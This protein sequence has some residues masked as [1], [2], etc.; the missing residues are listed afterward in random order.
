MD[1][2]VK[3]EQCTKPSRRASCSAVVETKTNAATLATPKRKRRLTEESS[4]PTRK[5]QR[6][7]NTLKTTLHVDD[8]VGDMGVI[9]EEDAGRPEC[10][11]NVYI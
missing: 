7:C 10:K 1:A 8:A 6:L 5:S 2:T 9:I 11:L 3:I 4:T